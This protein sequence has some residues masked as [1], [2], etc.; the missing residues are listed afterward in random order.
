[1]QQMV[2]GVTRL[3]PPRM[4]DPIITTL[5]SFY[6]EPKILP[7]L[8]ADAGTRGRPSDHFIPLMRPISELENRC[9]RSY[10]QVKVRPINRSGLDKLRSWFE[11]QNWSKVTGEESVNKKAENLLFEVQQAVNLYLPEKTI[12]ISSDDEPWYSQSLKK[13]DRKKEGSTIKTGGQQNTLF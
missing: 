3:D 7:P 13:L 2:N 1:M 5:G 6:Q 4:L 8:D 9:S 10:R 11:A 12:K